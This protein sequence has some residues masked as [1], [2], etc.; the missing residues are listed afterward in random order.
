M[1]SSGYFHGPRYHPEQNRPLSPRELA[2]AQSIPDSYALG[3]SGSSINEM[4]KIAGNAVPIVLGSAIG[5]SVNTSV[6]ALQLEEGGFART[7]TLAKTY[8]LE[9]PYARAKGVLEVEA[10]VAD[11]SDLEMESDGELEYV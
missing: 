9:N 11:D 5:K 3:R 7:R 6:R 10:E 4:I 8:L 1:N 2:R